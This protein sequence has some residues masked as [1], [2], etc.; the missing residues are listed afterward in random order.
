MDIAPLQ[1]TGRRRYRIKTRLFG[2]PL[3]V[4]QVEV[5]QWG[6]FMIANG[7]I[8]SEFRVWWRDAT[9]EDMTTDELVKG[10][11]EGHGGVA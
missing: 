11:L 10:A 2:E 1:L 7:P 3:L 9:I 8:E 5:R 6:S 4:L